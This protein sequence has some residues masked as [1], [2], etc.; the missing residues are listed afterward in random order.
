MIRTAKRAEELLRE[1]G[2]VAPPVPVEALAQRRGA[3]V[4]YTVFDDDI[5]GLLLRE[6]DSKIIGVHA[7]TTSPV[8]A[9]RSPMNSDISNCIGDVP[10]SLNICP[11]LGSTGVMARQGKRLTKKRSKPTSMRRPCSCP[12]FLW[13][14]SSCSS[15]D[16]TLMRSLLIA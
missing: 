14:R 12:L 2:V 13:N 16:N 1:H 5:S 11:V 4:R 6:G 10:R 9:S 3:E 8:S 7:G 15:L